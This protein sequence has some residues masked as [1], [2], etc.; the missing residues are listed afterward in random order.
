MQEKKNM[1]ARKDL[2]LH[3]V[4]HGHIDP[5]WLWRWTEGYEEVRAT[6]RSAL[7][8]MNETPEFKFTASSACFYDWVK[9]CDPAMFEEIRK[10]VKEGRWELAGGWW[11]EPDCNI[12]HGESFCRQG[13]YGQRF[14]EK[15]FGRRATVGFNPDSFGH[16]GTF[17]QILRK[18]GIHYYAYMRPMPDTEMDYPGGTTFFWRASDG[19]QILASTILEDYNGVGERLRSTI[20]KLAVSRHLNPGQ[21]EVL[22]FYGVGNHGGGPTKE[23]IKDIKKAQKA[24]GGPHLE[25]STLKEYFDSFEAASDMKKI[26]VI[27]RDLQHHAQGCYTTH[28]EVKR[29]NRRAEHE[30]MT[31]ERFATLAWILDDHVYPKDEIERAWKWVLYNQFHDILAGSSLESAY[32]DMRDQMGYA[33][34]TAQAITNESLQTLARSIDTSA[35]GNTLVVLNPL[36][37]PVKQAVTAAP[38]AARELES[39]IHVVDEQGKVVASQAVL[40]ERIG[41]TAHAFVAEVPAFGYRC[42]H[43]RSGQKSPALKGVL[44][45]GRDYLDNDWWRIEFDNRSGEITRLYDKQA[46]VDTLKRGNVLAAMVDS[47]DT[48]GHEMVEL[49]N[50]AGR[51]S[52]ARL[53]LLEAGPVRAAMRIVSRF[54]NS[55]ADQTV[56][57]YRGVN[58]ID[59]RFRINWQES[60]T[61]LKL[62][63][64]TAV[65]NGTAAYDSAYGS[66]MRNTQGWEEPGQ[67]W[68]DLTGQSGAQA[69]GFAV[70]NDSKYGFDVLDSTMRVT[71]LRST[72]Y[73]HHDRH[74]YEAS[75]PYAIMD[76]GWHSLHVR[77]MPHAGAWQKAGIVK[78]AWELNSPAIVHI[79]SAHDGDLPASASFYS[80]TAENVLLNVLKQSEEGED[81]V[82][83]G[84]ETEGEKAKLEIHVPGIKK[85]I[86]TTFNPH[87]IKTLRINRRTGKALE[88]DLLE[89]KS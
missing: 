68:F 55:T 3:M 16:A 51:F 50:E 28:A 35:E 11:I 22:G 5:T 84:Y 47:F 48:W 13:L 86:S 58:T 83:R 36:P 80:G 12:P 42:Y 69:Y 79:E 25:F 39:P 67:A 7:E 8:R 4:G 18:M 33:R 57:I 77:L 31:A 14:F 26:P 10:R 37:W 89:E 72:A 60:Y 78:K 29:L 19:S 24:K 66:Q 30:L 40:G 81:I 85:G 76:Q 38:I 74:R 27:D 6:F 49:R 65:E 32:E 75:S 20:A 17:P 71:V 46:K 52:D 41:H 82:V 62:G 61:T 23:S 44:E 2:T 15:E 21:T 87:E 43:A 54:R 56:T 45:G 70:L 1:G 53:E 34:A 9:R 59:C 88:V 63:Y 64:E 73:A